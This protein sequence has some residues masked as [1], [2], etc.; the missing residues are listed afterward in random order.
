MELSSGEGN[1]IS[2]TV[3]SYGRIYPGVLVVCLIMGT[4]PHENR[5]AHSADTANV[6]TT[7]RAQMQSEQKS[8]NP[9]QPKLLKSRRTR[10]K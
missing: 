4:E 3:V 9:E 1:T 6:I 8:R 5:A 2:S 7:A 10:K